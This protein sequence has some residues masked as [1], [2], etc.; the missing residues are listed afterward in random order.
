MEIVY[1]INPQKYRDENTY[2][3]VWTDEAEFQVKYYDKEIVS[4][5]FPQVD[6]AIYEVPLSELIELLEQLKKDFDE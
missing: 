4:I 6:T 2:N 1:K 3:D 5:G